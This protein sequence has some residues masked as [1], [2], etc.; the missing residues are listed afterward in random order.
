MGRA[1]I[2]PRPLVSASRL[3]IPALPQLIP[4]PRVRPRPVFP[5]CP[6]RAAFQCRDAGLG[7][8]QRRQPRGAHAGDPHPRL[9]APRA[10]CHPPHPNSGDPKPRRTDPTTPVR[11]SWQ[12]LAT[13]GWK[14]WRVCRAA[15]FRKHC[16]GDKEGHTAVTTGLG[17][18]TPGLVCPPAHPGQVGDDPVPADRSQHVHGPWVAGGA[19][20]G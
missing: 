19:G 15:S 7:I 13:V 17:G 18:V 2:T 4:A 14:A 6:P 10:P 9:A 11:C 3:C 20:M 12:A 8:A 5:P 1:G 16:E